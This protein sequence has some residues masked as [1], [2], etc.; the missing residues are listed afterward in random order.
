MLGKLLLLVEVDLQARFKLPRLNEVAPEVDADLISA[1]SLEFVLTL[2]RILQLLLK[3]IPKLNQILR[4]GEVVMCRIRF[5][6]RD[7]VSDSHDVHRALW[8]D[9][10]VFQLVKHVVQ[11]E[12]QV[13]LSFKF[14]CSIIDICARTK[15]N[16]ILM[17]L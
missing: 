11:Q 12:E 10:K 13:L 17:D 3:A 8:V 2:V 16:Y 4:G 14:I 15:L 6:L 5:D 7:G 1:K 9:G